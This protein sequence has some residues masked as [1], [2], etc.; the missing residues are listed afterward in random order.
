MLTTV[1]YNVVMPKRSVSL[2]L[3]DEVIED[4][5][6]LAAEREWTPSHF[7]ARAIERVVAAEKTKGAKR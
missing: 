1:S 6:K 2:R 7:M 4:V 3:D 5:R